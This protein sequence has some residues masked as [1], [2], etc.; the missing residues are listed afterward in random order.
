MGDK[1]LTAALR[2]GMSLNTHAIATALEMC[3]IRI[4]E[5]P[6]DTKELP[7]Q[8]PSVQDGIFEELFQHAMAEHRLQRIFAHLAS[9]YV[10]GQR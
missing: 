9:N 8:Y 1:F 4:Q 6:F 7:L 5:Q 10:I 3:H 2:G